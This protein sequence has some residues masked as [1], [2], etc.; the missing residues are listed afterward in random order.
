MSAKDNYWSVRLESAHA[1][2][3]R[4]RYSFVVLTIISLAILIGEFNSAFSWE[5]QFLTGVDGFADQ[6]ACSNQASPLCAAPE[7]TA[8]AQKELVEEWVR[9]NRVTI[10]LLGVNI[11]MADAALL[12]SLGLFLVTLW[13]YACIRRENHLIADLLIDA[14]QSKEQFIRVMM[15]HGIHAYMVFSTMTRDDNP[16]CELE[17]APRPKRPNPILRPALLMLIYLP[18]IT[19]F[20]V[21]FA[22]MYTL[23]RPGPLRYPHET[24]WTALQNKATSSGS[25]WWVF[26]LGFMELA[27]L[28]FFMMTTFLCVRIRAFE[29]CTSHLVASFYASAQIA[30]ASPIP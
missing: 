9:S 30:T 27:A 26:H 5:I 28:M 19:T 29:R 1:T 10:A 2:Q 15:Y 4:T 21:I 7:P 24:V 6:K 12:G 25:L 13:F 8:A 22:D 14:L 23:F 20:F 3:S 17:R 11:S 18:A 16:I